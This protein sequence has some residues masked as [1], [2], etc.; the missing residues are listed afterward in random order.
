MQR[1]ALDPQLTVRL[2]GTLLVGNDWRQ[3]IGS[4]LDYRRVLKSLVLCR[5]TLKRALTALSVGLIAAVAR[6]W[7]LTLHGLGLHTGEPC[8]STSHKAAMV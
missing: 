2:D 8:L 4:I 5:I 6:R 3:V 7:P 1:L